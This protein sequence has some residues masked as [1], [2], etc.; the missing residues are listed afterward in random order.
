MGA[1]ARGNGV[2]GKSR[3][4]MSFDYALVDGIYE[5]RP[6]RDANNSIIQISC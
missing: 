5:G 4:D 2:S 6:A 3:L 1:K